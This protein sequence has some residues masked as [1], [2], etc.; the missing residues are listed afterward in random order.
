MLLF[1]SV[2]LVPAVYLTGWTAMAFGFAVGVSAIGIAMER[3]LFLA[4]AEHVSQL[5]HGAARA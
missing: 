3:W 2:A 4:E 1:L 5:F